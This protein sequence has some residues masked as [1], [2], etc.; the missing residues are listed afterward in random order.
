MG[1]K[2]RESES[3]VYCN[4]LLTGLQDRTI[5]FDIDSYYNALINRGL[6]KN[7]TIILTTDLILGYYLEEVYFFNK[8]ETNIQQNLNTFQH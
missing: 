5:K 8:P 1:W 4:G 3:I 2:D 6:H 7:D